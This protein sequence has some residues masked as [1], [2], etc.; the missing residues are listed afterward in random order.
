[1]GIL[2]QLI[3]KKDLL[4]YITVRV[5]ELKK[6]RELALKLPK[7][8]REW[9][10]QLLAGRMKELTTLKT[11][12]SQKRL[13]TYSQEN[14]HWLLRKEYKMPKNDTENVSTAEVGGRAP[15]SW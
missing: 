4:T 5:A 2:D 11:M 14:W 12:V 9:A 1:M 7:K 3:E 8:E 6:E 13:R 10:R 15:D